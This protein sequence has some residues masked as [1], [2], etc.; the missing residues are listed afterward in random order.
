MTVFSDAGLAMMASSKRVAGAA[1]HTVGKAPHPTEPGAE[2]PRSCLLNKPNTPS[3]PQSGY[4]MSME[5][6]AK[7]PLTRDR[8][9]ALQISGHKCFVFKSSKH[10]HQRLRHSSIAFTINTFTRDPRICHL[11]VAGAILVVAF[12]ALCSQAHVTA[13]LSARFRTCIKDFAFPKRPPTSGIQPAASILDG[14]D[15]FQ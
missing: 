6:G 2:R 4:S 9:R 1:C 10:Q 11:G 15:L 7:R 8:N 3:P 13:T 12:G 14:Q 5:I